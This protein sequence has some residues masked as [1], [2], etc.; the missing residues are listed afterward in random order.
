MKQGGLDEV[1]KAAARRI[2]P[3]EIALH[4]PHHGVLGQFVSVVRIGNPFN[5]RSLRKRKKGRAA[6]T[7]PRRTASESPQRQKREEAREK[8]EIWRFKNHEEVWRVRPEARQ[9]AGLR[10]ISK[11]FVSTVSP[12]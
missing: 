11:S 2:G 3:G 5:M 1:A 12:T 6:R 10:T 8:R 9:V 7:Q 4:E